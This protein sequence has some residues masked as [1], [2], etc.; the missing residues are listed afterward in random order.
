MKKQIGGA[1]WVSLCSKAAADREAERLA[2]KPNQ[3]MVILKFVNLI[4]TGLIFSRP[5][6][7]FTDNTEFNKA[8]LD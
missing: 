1:M 8:A 7:D 5:V 2:S 4:K 3:R 6:H